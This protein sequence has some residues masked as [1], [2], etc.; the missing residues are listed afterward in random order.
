MDK[1]QNGI[2]HA[3][4]AMQQPRIMK[5]SAWLDNFMIPKLVVIFSLDSSSSP[6]RFTWGYCGSIHAT[7]TIACVRS[8][9]Y[10]WNMKIKKYCTNYVCDMMRKTWCANKFHTY[11]WCVDLTSHRV[12]FLTTMVTSCL[13]N[14]RWSRKKPC[15]L[16][17]ASSLEK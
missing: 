7:D 10:T 16:I 1:P 3:I 15:C 6:T 9:S 4:S 12:A 8:H 13:C 2:H 17:L 5:F 14:I 11:L